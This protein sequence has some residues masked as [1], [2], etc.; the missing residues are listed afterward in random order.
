MLEELDHLIELARLDSAWA[1]AKRAQ[2]E[3]P[4]RLQAL[5]RRLQAVRQSADEARQALEAARL[6][7]RRR[8]SDVQTQEAETRKL[9]TQLLQI[10]TNDAYRAMLREIDASKEKR[11]EIETAILV[12]MDREET[13]AREL[14]EKEAVRDADSRTLAGERAALEA[15]AERR[16]AHAAEV[17]AQREQVLARLSPPLR[18]R[19]ER[20]FGSKHGQAVALVARASCG[21]CHATLPPQVLAEVRRQDSVL[22]CEQCGR[23]LVWTGA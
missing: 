3:I 6:E 17:S 18:S 19:Y 5:E 16:A 11:S 4:G 10:K 12:L 13:L 15:E 7:R 14:K 22:V 9:E 2:E 8:E 23:L 1:E 20:V 21:G